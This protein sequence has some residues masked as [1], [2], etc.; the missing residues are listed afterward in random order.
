[1]TITNQALRSW[2]ASDDQGSLR[3]ALRPMHPA[4]IANEIGDMT[5]A[6]AAR[7]LRLLPADRQGIVFGYFDA[8]FQ[9]ALAR[10]LPRPD[11]A[12]VVAA[13][14]HDERADLWKR[15]DPAARD[16]LMPGL[17]QAEREDIRRLAAYPEGTAGALMTSDYATLA[18]GETVRQA[19]AHLRAEAPDAET[20][21]T[22]YVVDDDRRLLDRK[23]VV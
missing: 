14:S 7:L 11:L 12:Q 18:P 3:A 23:S 17:A 20:I 4:D 10:T 19:I 8:P 13:M 2:L 5:P 1:M 21:Y 6:E 9:I 16:A 22:A 15:L